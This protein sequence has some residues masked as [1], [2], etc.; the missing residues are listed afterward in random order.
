MHFV[1]VSTLFVTADSK[2]PLSHEEAADKVAAEAA[3]D[4]EATNKVSA[5]QAS[6]LMRKL[7][8]WW[9]L[10]HQLQPDLLKPG[11]S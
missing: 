8:P 9:Q 10:P 1:L 5:D 2:K 6:Q 7:K 11:C 4:E 3:A